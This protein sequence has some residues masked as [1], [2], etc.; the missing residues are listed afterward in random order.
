MKEKTL[1]GLAAARFAPKYVNSAVGHYQN[2]VQEFQLGKWENSIAKGGK[3]VEAVL[4]ALWSH[5]GESVPSGKRFKAG[6]IIDALSNKPGTLD[7]TV[8]LTMP[9]ACRLVYDVASN[10]GGR[11]DTG[12]VDPNEM[13]ASMVV[14]TC[15]WILAEMLRFSQKGIMEMNTVAELIASLN[16]RKFP[17][18]EEIDGRIYF[19]LKGLSARDV[20]L[21]TLWRIHPRRMSREELIAAARRHG[22]SKANAAVGVSRLCRVVDDDGH[23]N[24]RLLISGI[25]QAESL[26]ASKRAGRPEGEKKGFGV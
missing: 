1:S 3:F 4:K 25:Q 22:N 13:D 18:T 11:H 2:T 12:E 24:L 26:I 6:A 21:L 5:V 20:V 16:Q 10:R 8:R 19:S 9:R 7:D 14:A 23:G 15:S 17:F